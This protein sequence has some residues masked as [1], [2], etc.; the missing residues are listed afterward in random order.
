MSGKRLTVEDWYA[1]NPKIGKA[2]E[3]DALF[4]KQVEHMDDSNETIQ[5]Q[6]RQVLRSILQEIVSYP[7][8]EAE[9]DEQIKSAHEWLVNPDIVT[10]RELNSP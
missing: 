9:L 8:D 10:E 5:T 7:V 1:I 6:Q 4:L 3:L 2:M